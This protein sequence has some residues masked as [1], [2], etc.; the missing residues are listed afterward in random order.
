MKANDTNANRAGAK[1]ATRRSFLKSG[2]LL[3]V[4]LAAAAAPAAIA[5]DDSLKSRLAR[6]EDEAALRDL[7]DAWLRQFNAGA[8]DATPLL[9]ESSGAAHGQA[10]RRMAPDHAAGPDAFDIAPD[11]KSASGRFHCVVEIETPIARDSTLAEMAHAQGAGFVSRTDRR[12]LR[13]SYAKRS[14]GWAIA[15]AELEAV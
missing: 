13:V 14:G 8:A 10:I 4:P 1:N 2:A 9:A 3:A 11:G 15:S 6:L 5:A 12:L 7:H